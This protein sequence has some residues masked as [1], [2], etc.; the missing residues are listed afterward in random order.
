MCVI[1]LA[2]V[3]GAKKIEISD[4]EE[5][6]LYYPRYTITLKTINYDKLVEK[7]IQY[8]MENLPETLSNI[9]NMLAEMLTSCYK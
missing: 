5:I 7:T 9:V 8:S 4:D 3:S 6:K 1:Y 2:N